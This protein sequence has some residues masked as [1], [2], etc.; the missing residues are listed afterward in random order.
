M[1]NE[2][3][4]FLETRVPI[5]TQKTWKGKMA[6]VVCNHVFGKFSTLRSRRQKVDVLFSAQSALLAFY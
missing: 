5:R 2:K 1:W 4:N 3:M 6:N